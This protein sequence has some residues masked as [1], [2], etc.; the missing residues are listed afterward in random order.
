MDDTFTF[1]KEDDI[2]SVREALNGFHPDIKFTYE[3]EKDR[4]IAFLDVLITR[5]VDGTFDTEVYRKKRITA[6]ASTGMLMLHAPGNLVLSKVFLEELFWCALQIK[7][8]TR[9]SVS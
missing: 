1:I 3:A 9:K 5:K 2:D 7:L 8:E 4:K 6:S